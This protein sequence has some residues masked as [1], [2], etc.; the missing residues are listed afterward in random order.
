MMDRLKRVWPVEAAF[1]AISLALVWGINRWLRR[2]R[3]PDGSF[4]TTTSTKLIYGLLVIVLMARAALFINNVPQLPRSVGFDAAAHEAYIQF[5]QQKHALPMADDGWEMFQPPLYYLASALVLDGC[6][7]SVGDE[8]AALFLRAV[9]GVIGLLHCWVVLLCLRLLFPGNLPVQAAGLLVAA[10]LPPHLYL[11]QYVTNE[12][13]AGFLVTAA[14]YCCLRTLRADKAGLWM[15]LGIGAALGAAMLT[16]VSVLLAL[17]VFAV[18]LSQRLA[19][20][21]GRAWRDWLWSVGAIVVVC[22]LVCGWHYGRVWA[23][24]GKPI[25]GNWDLQP[26]QWGQEWWIEPGYITSAFYLSFG[27]VLTSPS[28]SGFHSFADGIYSTL[29]GDGLASGASDFRHLRP[30]WNYDLVGAGYWASLGIS[31]LLIIGA[32]LV[33]ARIMRQPRGEWLLV[34][35]MVA[36]FGL[37]LVW[38]SLRHPDF[39]CS[40][41]FYALSAL[42]PFSALAAAGWDWL[43]QRHRA[44]GIAAWVLLLVWSMTVYTSFWVRRANPAT[45]LLRAFQSG[46]AL[47]RQG[48][49]D[50]AIGQ[51]R[52]AIRLKPDYAKA[53][54]DL[55]VALGNQGQTGEAIGQYQEAIRLKPDY[56]DAHNNL[57]GALGLEGQTDAAI[58]QFRETLRLKP[59]QAE[60]H[61][62]LAI[63]LSQKGQTD[64]AIR[65]LHET[66]RLQPDHV[67]AHNTLGS[68]L[69][70]R[71]RVGEAIREFQEALRLKPDYA[72]ARKNLIIALAAQASPAPPPGAAT[73]R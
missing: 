2:K 68:A 6:G 51:F 27:R 67:Q 33:L 45:Q 4:P 55:G 73:N 24:F 12:P 16:K 47:L 57:G 46:S 1:C 20:R 72:E 58:L 40:K 64:E 69:Y 53:H 3:L 26:G 29:W 52:E 62:N 65:Q 17:P 36:S 61:Y 60:P 22:L 13:L 63:A 23:R 14:I 59:E 38:F 19:F 18:V 9:N 56:A 21:K 7:R 54:Y 10:F 49:L 43:R 32:A 71:G 70:Q 34:F 8:D 35:G 28:F 42:L 39:A 66:L 15:S 31:L 50:E 5:I 41:A 37:G 30:P 25:V 11:S 48:Q 44:V